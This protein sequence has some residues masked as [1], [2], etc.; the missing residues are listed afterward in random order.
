MK[1]KQLIYLVLAIVGAVGTWYFNLQMA[2]LGSF[3]TAVWDTPLTSSL[4]VDLLVAVL[5]FLVFMWPEGRRLGMNP[6]LLIALLVVTGMVA[7]AFSFPLF[8]FFRERAIAKVEA[9]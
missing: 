7:F 8:M 5:T 9:D 6:L 3:F 2:D 1:P 4:M